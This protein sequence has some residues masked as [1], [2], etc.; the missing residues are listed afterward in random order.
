M[1][2]I[3]KIETN[4]SKIYKGEIINDSLVHDLVE[5]VLNLLCTVVTHSPM[6]D[7]LE[8]TQQVHIKHSLDKSHLKHDTRKQFSVC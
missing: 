3:H 8:I 6:V 2:Y 5:H 1:L 4:K 7:K